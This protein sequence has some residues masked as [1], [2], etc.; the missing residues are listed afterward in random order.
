MPQPDVIADLTKPNKNAD[1]HLGPKCNNCAGFGYTLGIAGSDHGCRDCNQTG[2]AAM[3]NA[4]LQTEVL[5]LHEKIDKL[6]KL[7]INEIGKKHE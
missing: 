2:V 3:T 1:G 7:I 5:A 4:E 6:A